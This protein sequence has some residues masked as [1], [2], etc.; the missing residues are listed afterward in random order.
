MTVR[1]NGP[2]L[3]FEIW[4]LPGNGLEVRPSR[5]QSLTSPQNVRIGLHQPVV[6]YEPRGDTACKA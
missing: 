1:N 2:D 6:S 5:L 4:Y 3:P